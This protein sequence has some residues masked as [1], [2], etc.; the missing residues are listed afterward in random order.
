MDKVMLNNKLLDEIAGRIS[1][2]AAGF[3][4]APAA[5]FEKN[6]KAL[7]SSA[8]ARMDLVTREE[9]DVQREILL[10]ARERLETLEAEVAKLAAELES[11]K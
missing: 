6:A 5:E 2:L 9:F 3:P 8:F 4:G 7:L 1:Q 10:K 11:R